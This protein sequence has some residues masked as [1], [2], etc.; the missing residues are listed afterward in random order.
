M[1]V[2]PSIDKIIMVIDNTYQIKADSR[3]GGVGTESTILSNLLYSKISTNN[4]VAIIAEPNAKP[5]VFYSSRIYIDLSSEDKLSE[6]YESLIRWIFG[7]FKH[8]RPKTEGVTP[9]FIHEDVDSV[10]LYTNMEFRN[11][12]TEIERGKPTAQG[13]IRRYLN[14]LEAEIPKLS[15][16]GTDDPK[17][18]FLDNFSNFSAHLL[19]YKK[20]LNTACEYH[21][22]EKT[23]LQ[24]QKFIANLLKF[25]RMDQTVLNRVFF[26][27]LNY[28]LLLTTIAVLIKNDEL[29]IIKVFLDEIYEVPRTHT[30]FHDEIYTTF[31]I[32]NPTD[33]QSIN[34]LLDK[35]NYVE[36]LAE[37]INQFYDD[38]IV[39]FNELC[40][41]DL[42]LY[43]KSASKT[44]E[45]KRQYAM[46]WPHL[47]FYINNQRY[48]T[49][50]FARAENPIFLE[51]LCFVFNIK[52]LSLIDDIYT[53]AEK[54]E[55][56]SVYI[57]QWRSPFPRFLN[58][59]ILTNFEKLKPI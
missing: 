5:P 40:E 12:L 48:P 58:L 49:K 25:P 19:E 52:D 51:K 44:I 7:V 39:T 47:T 2:D 35:D 59:K 29:S 42:I 33:S 20:L 50:I 27:A 30:Q 36:P 22:E 26:E 6:K 8:E 45:E 28:Q 37:L 43:L 38:E 10:V 54:Q 56:D 41:A 16:D 55:W 17:K 31:R 1:V 13:S 14:K 24:F 32:F 53:I 4:V 46:W 21:L 18:A 15:I 3:D 34:E 9:S 23:L 11:A 57:P